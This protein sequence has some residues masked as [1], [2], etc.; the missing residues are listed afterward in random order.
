M[1]K[2]L[3]PPEHGLGPRLRDIGETLSAFAVMRDGLRF[4]RLSPDGRA[5]MPIG[6]SAPLTPLMPIRTMIGKARESR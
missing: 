6:Y 3:M 5:S 4:R 1:D 2:D